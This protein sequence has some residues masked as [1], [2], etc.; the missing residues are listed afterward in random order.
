[1]TPTRL[2]FTAAALLGLTISPVQAQN[3]DATSPDALI[4]IIQEL[5]YKALAD[6]DQQGDPLIRSSANGGDFTIYFY[7]CNEGKDCKAIQYSKGYDM[8]DGMAL[9]RVNEWNKEHRFGKVYLDAEM[10]PYIEMDVNMDL[11]GVN[12]K[13]FED[14]FDWWLVITREFEEFIDWK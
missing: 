5:G 11:G 14:T 8:A 7:G 9:E 1:M 13:N 12:R 4:L 3:V 6:T 2:L 10:D